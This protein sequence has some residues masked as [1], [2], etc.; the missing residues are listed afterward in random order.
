[1]HSL[2]AIRSRRYIERLVARTDYY[3]S[4]ETDTRGAFTI[5]ADSQNSYLFNRKVF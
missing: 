2:Y 4:R 5:S 3:E 1:M